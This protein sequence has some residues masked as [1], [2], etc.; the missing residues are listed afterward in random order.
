MKYFFVFSVIQFD[1]LIIYL[2]NCAI[3]CLTV[4]SYEE[5]SKMKN[6]SKTGVGSKN[7]MDEFVLLDEFLL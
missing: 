6:R 4:L 1:L 5:I 7:Q 2:L 3:T